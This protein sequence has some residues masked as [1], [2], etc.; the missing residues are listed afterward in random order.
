MEFLGQGS[1]LSRRCDLCSLCG[2]ARS[3]EP[4]R[5]CILA[6]RFWDGLERAALLPRWS[7]HSNGRGP[8]RVPSQMSE[9][10]SSLF[11]AGP[12]PLPD[13]ISS[14][15]STLWSTPRMQISISSAQRHYAFRVFPGLVLFCWPPRGAYGV[16]RPG[17][18]SKLRCAG[19]LTHCAGLGIKPTS[20]RC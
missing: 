1:D 7:L 11:P 8:G 2:N 5:T 17:V 19:S 10:W 4:P 3:L 6:Q 13:P 14:R 18:R 16:P 15:L 9:L 20:Q 12:F